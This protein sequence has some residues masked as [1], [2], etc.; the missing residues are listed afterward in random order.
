MGH[1]NPTRHHW[2]WKEFAQSKCLLCHMT[3]TGHRPIPFCGEHSDRDHYL[4]MLT[5]WLHTARGRIRRLHFA[6]GRS[7]AAHF[8]RE[9]RRFLNEHKPRCWIGRSIRNT[10][11]PLEE[12]PPRSPDITPWDFLLW[13]CVKNLVFVP[14]LPRNLKEMKESFL[15]TVST[16][17]DDKLQRVWEGWRVTCDTR[18]AYGASV[19]LGTTVRVPIRIIFD[20]VSISYLATE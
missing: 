18:G 10:D 14:L 11:L 12:W 6:A 15:S 20:Y 13:G 7:S 17:N 3:H 19:R 1:W 16:I 5:E 9:V 8:Q 4:D 2:T